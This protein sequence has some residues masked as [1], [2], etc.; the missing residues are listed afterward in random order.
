ME[1]GSARVPRAISG[2]PPEN[3][4]RRDA[5]HH[6]RD[7]YAPQTLDAE[8]VPTG[9]H[10]SLASIQIAHPARA[11]GKKSLSALPDVGR[12]SE[13]ER[14]RFQWLEGRRKA[15]RRSSADHSNQPEI[16]RLAQGVW[17]IQLC[18][19]GAERMVSLL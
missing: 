4:V 9:R 17:Q 11:I 10:R 3:P 6:T 13:A 12:E 16:A 1:S 14:K 2:V 8:C 18:F 5:E 15:R 7:A 19:T